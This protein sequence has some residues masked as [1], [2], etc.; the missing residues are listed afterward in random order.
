MIACG[1]RWQKQ[2]HVEKVSKYRGAES[3]CMMKWGAVGASTANE[4]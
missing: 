2:K 1:F 4:N 3:R